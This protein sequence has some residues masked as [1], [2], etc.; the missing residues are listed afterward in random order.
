MR[1]R[2]ALI[3]GGS[4]RIFGTARI[5]D[6]KGPMTGVELAGHRDKHQVPPDV[7]A[8]FLEKYDGKAHAWVLDDVVRFQKP[9]PYQHPSGAVIWVTLPDDI[10]DGAE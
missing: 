10:L 6:S 7:L 2:V 8:E 5:V 9:R 4:G 3:K 1:E